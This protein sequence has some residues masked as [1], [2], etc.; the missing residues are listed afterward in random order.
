MSG[1][2]R[3]IDLAAFFENVNGPSCRAVPFCVQGAPKSQ[4]IRPARH[5]F[6]CLVINLLFPMASGQIT[7]FIDHIR[8]VGSDLPV[9]HYVIAHELDEVPGKKLLALLCVGIIHVIP[10]RL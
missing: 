4:G 6:Q 8:I 1:I 2:P 9:N 7:L 10:Y 3:S 5:F